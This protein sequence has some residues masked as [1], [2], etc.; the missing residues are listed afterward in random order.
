[1]DIAKLRKELREDRKDSPVETFMLLLMLVFG[2]VLILC[3]IGTLVYLFPIPVISI[4]VS[5]GI[6][7]RLYMK[8]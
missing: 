7:Y 2:G 5:V 3:F 1:M 8:I 6:L 4:V